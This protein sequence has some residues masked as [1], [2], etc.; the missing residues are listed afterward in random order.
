MQGTGPWLDLSVAVILCPPSSA[1]ENWVA[2]VW[3]KEASALSWVSQPNIYPKKGARAQVNVVFVLP[4]QCHASWASK[5]QAP[6]GG[7]SQPLRR[8]GKH[9][10]GHRV[11][12]RERPLCP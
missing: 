12:A 7:R 3:G 1:S 9:R 4:K 8:P 5:H 6:W 2:G 11:G 10:T